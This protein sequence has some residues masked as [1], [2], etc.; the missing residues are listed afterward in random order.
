[1]NLLSEPAFKWFITIATGGLSAAWLVYDIVNLIRLRGADP[2][3]P[4]TGDRRFGYGMGIV[5]AIVG[6]V[7]AL[8]FQDVI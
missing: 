5:M 7:G 2:R 3:D 4:I 6:V 1:M 8:R